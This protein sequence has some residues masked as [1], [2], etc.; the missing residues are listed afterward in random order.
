MAWIET[1]GGN[2]VNLERM[3]TITIEPIFMAST[4]YALD[5]IVGTRIIARTVEFAPCIFVS[6]EKNHDYIAHKVM[7]YIAS[8]ASSNMMIRQ[9][10]IKNMIEREMDVAQD[11]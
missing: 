7:I 8:M 5:E 9:Q 10:D 2:M 4:T 6:K 3:D 11:N 1:V